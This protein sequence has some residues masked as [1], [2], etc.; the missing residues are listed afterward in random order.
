MQLGRHPS[1]AERHAG[2]VS[3]GSASH[4]NVLETTLMGKIA[5]MEMLA[6]RCV[7]WPSNTSSDFVFLPPPS[8]KICFLFVPYGEFLGDFFFYPLGTKELQNLFFQLKHVLKLREL[9]AE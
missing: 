4:A 7:K 3:I 6:R 5:K 8:L 2:G 1:A 9:F